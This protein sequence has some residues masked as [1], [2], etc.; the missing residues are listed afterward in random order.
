MRSTKSVQN[1]NFSA[2]V[3]ADNDIGV[4]ITIEIT[5]GDSPSAVPP[6]NFIGT[7]E[8]S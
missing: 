1:T 8:A 2:V 7:Y 5:C 4:P 3:V 6:H